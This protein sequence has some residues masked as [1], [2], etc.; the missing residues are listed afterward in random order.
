MLTILLIVAAIP[1]SIIIFS[2]KLLDKETVG[3]GWWG[4]FRGLVPWD[5]ESKNYLVSGCIC[6]NFSLYVR[7]Q[8]NK[9]EAGDGAMCSK[10]NW[11]D[12]HLLTGDCKKILVFVFI[13]CKTLFITIS[14]AYGTAK[15]NVNLRFT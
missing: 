4:R 3:G 8:A 2:R 7:R 15:D 13:I 6:D 14:S 11:T 12:L 9:T 1:L 5:G 10:A